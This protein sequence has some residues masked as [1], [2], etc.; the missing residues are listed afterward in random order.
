MSGLKSIL[1]SMN[2]LAQKAELTPDEK[3]HLADCLLLVEQFRNNCEP[4]LRV[5]KPELTPEEK[6]LRAKELR[7][8][9]IAKRL[10]THRDSINAY[11]NKFMQEKYKNTEEFRNKEK[12]RARVRGKIRNARLKLEREQAKIITQTV[13]Q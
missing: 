8:L 10:L 5:K 7:K 3:K 12:E 9:Y 2:I 1:D 13:E 11:M 6:K 4:V